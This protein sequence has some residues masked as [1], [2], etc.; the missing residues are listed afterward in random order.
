MTDP[1]K[2]VDSMSTSELNLVIILYTYQHNHG[3]NYSHGHELSI[4]NTLL[5]VNQL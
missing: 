1:N 4:H 2:C 3:Q 5:H